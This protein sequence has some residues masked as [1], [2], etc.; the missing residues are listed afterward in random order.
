MNFLAHLALSCHDADLQMGNF[1]GDYTKG[2]PPSH[3]P[4]G[5]IRG[6]TLHRT[7]DAFTDAHPSVKTMAQRIKGRHGRYAGV[8]TDVIFDLY[9]YRNW[10][11]MGLV[12]FDHFRLT[13]YD[14]L[15]GQTHYL[16][17]ALAQR[18]TNMV[19]A[20]WL[21]TYTTRS[22]IL[23]VFRRMR[24]RFSRPEFLAEVDATLIEEDEAFNQSFL[25]LFPD[26]QLTVNTFC[27]C[28]ETN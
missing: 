28:D 11:I 14:N 13:T 27:G 4:P 3:Y 22:G 25:E 26:L 18:V 2:K 24:R 10:S 9:L 5:I 15:L 1:L 8:I 16:D 7:I 17:P 20:D 6:I 12:D 23:D 21:M 19:E